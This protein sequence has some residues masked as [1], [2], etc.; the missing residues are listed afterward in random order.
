[1][2]ILIE[3]DSA[4]KVPREV[5]SLDE[6]RAFEAQGFTVCLIGEDG[7]ASPLPPIEADDA[8]VAVGATR[9]SDGAVQ[10][11]ETLAAAVAAWNAKVPADGEASHAD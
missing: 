4:T 7:A 10:T 8:F 3:K 5:S 11:E 9:F 1:M 2:H 6:A